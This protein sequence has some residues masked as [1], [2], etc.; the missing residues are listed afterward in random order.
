MDSLSQCLFS[1]RASS[2][3]NFAV[4][5]Q[6]IGTGSQPERR[7][8]Q[9]ELENFFESHGFHASSRSSSNVSTRRNG[10]SEG[11]SGSHRRS[12]PSSATP[13][14]RPISMSSAQDASSKGAKTQAGVTS[15]QLTQMQ[16]VRREWEQMRM[17][18]K[19]ASAHASH[20]KQRSPTFSGIAG[21][22]QSPDHSQT[23]TGGIGGPRQRAG[24]ATGDADTQQANIVRQPGAS[25]GGS[26]R[27]HAPASTGADDVQQ[28]PQAGQASHNGT[29]SS[30]DPH[31]QVCRSAIG[32]LSSFFWLLSGRQC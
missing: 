10:S 2:C 16:A 28:A 23:G 4:G 15:A 25:R 27:K 19:G 13:L 14:N 11:W 17:R 8:R 29:G 6:G 1:C 9:C 7:G 20:G 30:S 22:N 3:R 24:A 12:A 32:K 21:T 5:R 18:S 26:S 31:S